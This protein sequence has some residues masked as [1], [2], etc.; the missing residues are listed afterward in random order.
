MK[1]IICTFLSKKVFAL[2]LALYFVIPSALADSRVPIRLGD[3]IA[4]SDYWRDKDILTKECYF[5]P[6]ASEQDILAQLQGNDAPDLFGLITSNEDFEVFKSSVTLA[7][8]SG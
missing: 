6:F 3:N 1:K 8:L 5:A 4:V 7:D 2:F